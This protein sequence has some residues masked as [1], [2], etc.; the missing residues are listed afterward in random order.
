MII[1]THAHIYLEHFKDDIEAAMQRCLD[2]DVQKIVLPNIDLESIA[3][4]EK[5][6]AAYPKM[7]FPAMGLHPCS[8][9]QNWEATLATIK[10][11][12][13]NKLNQ[14][15]NSR[16]YGI[17]EIGLDYY[18]DT[19][20]KAQQQA[21]L[22]TQIQW[23]KDLKLPIIL[24]ARDSFDDLFSIVEEMNDE[25]LSG[26]FHCFGGTLS[27]AE[28]IMGLGNFYMGIGGVVTFKKTKDLR[29]T[30]KQVPLENIVLETDAPY[31]TPMPYRG[32]RNESSYTL[33]VAEM[34]AT[35]YQKGLDEVSEITTA[36]AERLFKLTVSN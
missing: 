1:D 31:L 36:N 13:D 15:P 22:R 27:D 34:L 3:P 17:G 18:W 10:D 6:T 8:V 5:L 16:I 24:H 25:N 26:I 28:K 33:Y 35:V 11:Y 14:L 12:I 2:N 29:D 7:C 30:L 20:F 9:D 19:T 32:K 4:I 21:A 23:A